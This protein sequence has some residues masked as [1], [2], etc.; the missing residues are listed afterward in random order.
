MIFCAL[1]PVVSV[2]MSLVTTNTF[3]RVEFVSACL[4]ITSLLTTK[5]RLVQSMGYLEKS[6]DFGNWIVLWWREFLFDRF[7]FVHSLDNC[8]YRSSEK[9]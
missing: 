9:D 1:K 4:E 6:L 2:T 8:L 3:G 7:V 5:R